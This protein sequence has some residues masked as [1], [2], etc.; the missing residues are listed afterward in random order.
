MYDYEAKEIAKK[1]KNKNGL[2]LILISVIIATIYIGTSIHASFEYE[3]K[4]SSSWN[5]A[6][7]ASQIKQKTQYIDKFVTT[8]ENSG[9]QGKYNAV[10]LQTPDNSFDKNLEALKSLQS[11]LHNI[12]AMDENSLAYQQAIFQITQHE[13]GEALLMT[14]TFES[15][16]YKEYHTFLWGWVA[17]PLYF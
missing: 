10:W 4:I 15:I 6:D 8:L 9:L 14:K 16:W 7:K 3:N 11:R 13:Q 12:Q 5:L 2:V 17:L 1:R